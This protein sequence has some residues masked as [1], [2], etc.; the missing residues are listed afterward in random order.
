MATIGRRLHT[1]P[2]KDRTHALLLRRL[3]DADTLKALRLV[4]RPAPLPE[5]PGIDAA[6]GPTP[7][8]LPG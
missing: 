3:L 6:D 1:G 5:R 4:A 8:V 2:T 7:T